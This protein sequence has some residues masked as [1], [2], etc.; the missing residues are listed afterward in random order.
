MVVLVV[1]SSI[2]IALSYY[3]IKKYTMINSKDTISVKLILLHIVCFLLAIVSS[4]ILFLSPTK[5]FKNDEIGTVTGQKYMNI[6]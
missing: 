2:T 6:T 4:T 5:L 1:V 3:D